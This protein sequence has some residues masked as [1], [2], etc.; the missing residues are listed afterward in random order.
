M[1]NA[2]STA[3]FLTS[4]P[5]VQLHGDYIA[6]NEQA[7]ARGHADKVTV[8]AMV[9]RSNE[10]RGIDKQVHYREAVCSLASASKKR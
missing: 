5:G 8:R 4:K 9:R 7:S 3:R 1:K 6:D 10:N 2:K